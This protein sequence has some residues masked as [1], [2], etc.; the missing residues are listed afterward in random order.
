MRSFTR[1]EAIAAAFPEANIDTDKILAGRFLKTI[2]RE[3]LGRF[4]FHSMRF[5]EE[6]RERAGF[7]LNRAPWREAGILIALDNF[8]CGSSR[9]HAPWA[10]ADFG[11]R[12]IV[13]PSFADIFRNNC[14]KNGILPIELD[15]DH[16]T[17]LIALASDPA[18][19][20]MTI[21]LAA[22]TLATEGMIFH[23]SIAPEEKQQLL[24]GLDEISESEAYLEQI[25][26]FERAADYACPSIPP[27][28]RFDRME[29]LQ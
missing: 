2:R 24:L 6:G 11:I 15:R 28:F 4:L 29:A 9:E 10:L 20:R 3:G 12:A 8:G 13:A 16:V 19:A 18:C 5:D 22:Q 25:A 21:D 26:A 14:R 27:G 7:I 1:L 23:F 17:R